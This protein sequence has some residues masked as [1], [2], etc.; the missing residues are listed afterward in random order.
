MQKKLREER[1]AKIIEMYKDGVETGAIAK[2][3]GVI[4][5]TVTRIVRKAVQD[6]LVQPRKSNFGKPRPPKGQGKGYTYVKKGYKTGCRKLSV[7]QQKA[8]IDDYT[9][10]GL[11]YLQLMEK[12]NI[13]QKTVMHVLKVWGIP[14]LPRGRR[15]KEE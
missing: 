5:D 12:Y 4:T 8:L 10:N 11:T 15:A 14:P 2:Q 9:N 6:G 3:F 13:W 1:N 7:D